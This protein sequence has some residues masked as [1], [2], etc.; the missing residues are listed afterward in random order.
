MTDLN[1]PSAPRIPPK[2]ADAQRN[3]QMLLDVAAALF[4]TSGVEVP[5]REIAARAGVGTGTIYRHFPTRAELIIA[6]YRHQVETCA[7]AGPVLLARYVSPYAA[8]GEWIQLFVDFLATKHGLADVMQPGDPSFDALHRYLIDRL[9][10]VCMAFLDAAVEADE[11]RPDI[12]AYELMRGVGNL[13]IGAGN[14][15]HYDA[16]RLVALL[17]AGL[18][19]AQADARV[20]PGDEL[21]G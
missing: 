7:E 21:S 14:D 12:Q 11:I 5:V 3:K 4:V 20:D 18:R 2:R 8:L 1:A 10:P 15:A 16:R 13:C 17:I 9:V 19:R 6:V